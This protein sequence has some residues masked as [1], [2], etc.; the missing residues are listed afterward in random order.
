[1]SARR[2]LAVV[3][4]RRTR[5][6]VLW[7]NVAL[8]VGSILFAAPFLWLVSTT[9]KTD[10]EVFVFPPRLP[11]L[12]ARVRHS[13]YST[14]PANARLARPEAA[15]ED[16][17]E[18]VLPGLRAAMDERARL[19]LADAEVPQ[20]FADWDALVAD[21]G[22]VLLETAI[23]VVPN[24]AWSEPDD[25]IVRAVLA[26]ADE[27]RAAEVLARV[28]RQVRLG[29]VSVTD[30]S[31]SETLVAPGGELAGWSA[32]G[33]EA[34]LA[35]WSG[36]PQRPSRL[37]YSAGRQDVLCSVTVDL[38]APPLALDSLTV[39]ICEDESFHSVLLSVTTREGVWAAGSPAALRTARP[40]DLVFKFPLSSSLGHEH[41]P[42]QLTAAA[43]D[44]SLAEGQARVALTLHPVPYPLAVARKFLASY[45]DALG[46]VPMLRYTANSVFLVVMNVAGQLV[47]C[48]LVAYSFA[49]LRWP[50]R[51]VCFFV[52]IATM[53][54][55]PQVTIIPV[56]VILSKIGWFDTFLPLWVPSFF[57]APF[58]IFL[59]R[60]SMLG[61]PT[62]LEDAARIDGCGYFRIWREV[63]L[64]LA[65]PTLAAI[66]IFTFMYSW[67][68]F[69]G[70]LVYIS[71]PERI[72]LSLGLFLFRSAHG[73]EWP[74]MMAAA[75][76]MMLPVIV[77]FFLA[78]KY[79]IQGVTLTGIK[80]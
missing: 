77:I 8:V 39:P 57:G 9:F 66:A 47:A 31:G 49:R 59:L 30:L 3:G 63:M 58:F 69:F 18:T 41:I 76:M 11:R 51:N 79:F 25:G 52:L 62:D 12:P 19:L 6:A 26:E 36:D 24:A 48:S 23:A 13:P 20:H 33:G 35:P 67:N 34:I 14:L 43:G 37:I 38:P 7:H 17:W 75:T 71:S 68:D 70:P 10:E 78:Q 64:P 29:R 65:K 4:R 28:I 15:R 50:G 44:A 55:P 16:R 2:R 80:G 56:F 72:P 45:G 40:R 32:V 53:M 46:F 73:A 27:A 74:M 60:Q 22:R 21:T 1:M 5:A 54:L 61:I 42:L